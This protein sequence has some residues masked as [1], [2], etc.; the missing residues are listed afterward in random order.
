M[1][2]AQYIQKVL[3]MIGLITLASSVVA[4]FGVTAPYWKGSPLTLTP[5]ET[6]EITFTLQNMVGDDDLRVRVELLQDKR[7]V[8]LID[9]ETEYEIPAKTK[10]IPVRI[11]IKIPIDIQ[12]GT[13]FPIRLSFTS[14]SKLGSQQVQLGTGIEKTFDVIIEGGEP[15]K[16]VAETPAEKPSAQQYQLLRKPATPALIVLIMVF[17]LWFVLRKHRK[18]L[19][20]RKESSADNNARW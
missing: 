14:T 13:T 16:Q 8:E 2:N 4:A 17:I 3:L 15:A 11:R 18:K 20:E 5:G 6:R 1:N 9:T 7:Y 10:D 12:L 19:Q